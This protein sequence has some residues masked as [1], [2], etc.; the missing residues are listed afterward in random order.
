MAAAPPIIDLTRPDAEIAK[1]ITEGTIKWGFVYVRSK[2]L[3]FDKKFLDSAFGLAR[4]LFDSDYE[5]K[6]D[7]ACGKEYNPAGS[8]PQGL[9]QDSRIVCRRP[10]RPEEE[11]GKDWFA[12]GHNPAN[13]TSGSNL[14]FCYYPTFN[15]EQAKN[16][17][18]TA[19]P[20]EPELE[21]LTPENEW[22]PVAVFPPGTEDDELMPIVMSIGDLLSYWTEGVMKS[23]IHRVS[24]DPNAN[25]DRY[26]IVYFSHPLGTTELVT[27]PSPVA[28]QALL[29][30][31]PVN[32]TKPAKDHVLGPLDD[33]FGAA[34][35]R[36]GTQ[37]F[38]QMP[39]QAPAIAV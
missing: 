22:E 14:R 2:A 23:T 34:Y 36:M 11:G 8:V 39:V 12:A 7:V 28:R 3:D 33:V 16:F 25:R 20:S 37:E 9:Y 35:K 26:S 38:V 31:G 4:K 21:V 27:T 5:V 6:A 29:D 10:S 19:R 18:P 15:D 17:D 30:K 32:R 24:I 13:G 1:E